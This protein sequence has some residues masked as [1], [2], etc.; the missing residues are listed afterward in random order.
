MAKDFGYRETSNIEEDCQEGLLFCGWTNKW[1]LKVYPWYEKDLIIFSFIEKGKQGKGK[2]FDISI[3]AKKNYVFDFRDFSH[4]IL[5]DIN[6]PYDFVSIMEKEKTAGEKYPKRYKF[7]AGSNGE[8]SL[9]FCN[10]TIDGYEYCINASAV[11][12]DKKVIVNMP[13]SYY[14]IYGMVVAFAET[15]RER[16]Q[17]LGRILSHGIKSRDERIKSA[18][19][20][21]QVS[22][23]EVTTTSSLILQQNG[24]YRIEALTKDGEEIIICITQQAIDQMDAAR[25]GCF[26]QFQKRTSEKRTEFTFSGK[27]IMKGSKKE[28]IFEQFD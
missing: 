15:Y 23:L 7:I 13:M 2:S 16:E 12:D 19:K 5:H 4:E 14:D 26:Q 28:Y 17:E 24:D 27:V 6:T 9:G 20:M 10:S 3:P 18:A 25:E 22:G 8:K 21:Q 1:G 11:K